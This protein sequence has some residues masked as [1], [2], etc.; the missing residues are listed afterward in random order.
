[1]VANAYSGKGA[2]SVP[3]HSLGVVNV[4]ATEV[5]ENEVLVHALTNV[6]CM[7]K[8]G[9][10]AIKQSSDFVNEYPCRDQDGGLLAGPSENPN[11]LLGSFPSLFPYREGGFEV[12]QLCRVSYEAHAQWSLPMK[13]SVS[14][15]TFISYFKC[16]AYCKNSNFVQQLCCKS[17]RGFSCITKEK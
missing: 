14:M 17:R 16:L 5:G 12:D 13:I 9:A 4:A 7:E 11:H 6:S 1:M 8:V 15:K 10:W 3:L 2:Q